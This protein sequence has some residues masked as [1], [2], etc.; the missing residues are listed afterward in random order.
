MIEIHD[1]KQSASKL[2][3]TIYIIMTLILYFLWYEQWHTA[4]TE[5]YDYDKSVIF[6]PAMAVVF[7]YLAIFQQDA[8]ELRNR[9][10]KRLSS[11]DPSVK[12]PLPKKYI[13]LAAASFMIGLLNLFFISH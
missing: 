5:G 6:I 2:W 12:T 4:L 9:G 1:D 11:S 8:Y 13:V 7:T 3:H 10:K